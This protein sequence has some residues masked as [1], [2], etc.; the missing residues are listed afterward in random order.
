MATVKESLSRCAP[1]LLYPC[2]EHCHDQWLQPNATLAPTCKSTTA[3][4]KGASTAPTCRDLNSFN[5]AWAVPEGAV[6]WSS[7]GGGRPAL[8]VTLTGNQEPCRTEITE[9][10]MELGSDVSPTIRGTLCPLNICLL[11]GTLSPLALSMHAPP[12]GAPYHPL[13]IPYMPPV[14]H[15]LTRCPLHTSHLPPSCREPTGS[16][17]QSTHLSTSAAWGPVLH[18]H[19]VLRLCP[20]VQCTQRLGEL[21][22]EAYKDAHQKSVAVCPRTSSCPT[23]GS[24]SSNCT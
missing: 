12:W 20:V 17:V 24:C 10:A 7:V 22:T 3:P 13:P 9:A 19:M 2:S 16:H 15:S 5:C 21:I 11:W 4:A 14:R 1:C 23:A 8:Q 18:T 6:G